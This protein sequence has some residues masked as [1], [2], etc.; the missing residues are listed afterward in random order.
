MLPTHE[1]EWPAHLKSPEF[2]PTRA[3]GPRGS[4]LG[5]KST[6]TPQHRPQAPAEPRRSEII[7]G[8]LSM[9][10]DGLLNGVWVDEDVIRLRLLAVGEPV[11]VSW[12]RAAEIVNARE[13]PRKLL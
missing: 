1:P 4:R 13:I 12:R 5:P 2:R 7:E 3:P 6:T 8:L 11:Y 9:R 10:R